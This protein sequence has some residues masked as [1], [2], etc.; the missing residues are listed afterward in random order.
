MNNNIAKNILSFN[1]KNLSLENIYKEILFICSMFISR[2]N[3][4]V[5]RHSEGYEAPRF[6]QI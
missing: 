4:Y 3:F 6:F 2:D 5:V 1:K